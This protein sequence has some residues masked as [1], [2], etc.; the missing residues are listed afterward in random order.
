M[1]LIYEFRV[2]IYDW[3]AFKS[4]IVNPKSEI[5]QCGYVKNHFN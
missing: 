1:I 3:A 4:K 2:T 5:R